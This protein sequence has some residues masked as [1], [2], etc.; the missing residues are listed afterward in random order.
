MPVKANFNCSQGNLDSR[1]VN[2]SPRQQEVLRWT[3]AGKT[4]WE[5]SVIMRCTESNVNYHLKQL[6]GKLQASNKTHAVSKAIRLGLIVSD[7]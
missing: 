6:F 5:T 2:L 3:A 7:Q 1:D 4:T